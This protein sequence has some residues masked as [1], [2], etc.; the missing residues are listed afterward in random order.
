MG[1]YWSASVILVVELVWTRRNLKPVPAYWA[2]QRIRNCSTTINDSA[3]SCGLPN[4]ES[5]SSNAK[6]RSC[7]AS[8]RNC[9]VKVIDPTIAATNHR[10][11]QAIRPAVVNRKVWG[12]NRTWLGAQAQGILMSV[13][14]TCGQR[15]IDP[16]AFLIDVLCSRQPQLVPA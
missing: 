14:R 11:E 9:A 13:I 15:A 8:S 5:R 7:Y 2:I 16:F 12:G 4:S 1:A 6:W 3:R 10:A